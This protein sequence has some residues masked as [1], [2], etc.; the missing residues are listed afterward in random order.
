MAVPVRAEL[1]ADVMQDGARLARAMRRMTDEA[2]L[3]LEGL[4]RGLPRP[5]Q[6][7]AERIQTLDGCVERLLHARIGYFQRRQELVARLFA[8][9][10]TPRQQMETH[11]LAVLHAGERLAA[12]MRGLLREKGQGLAL[13]R[14]EG[15]LLSDMLTRLRD[16]FEALARLL[17]S[18]SYEQVLARGFALVRDGAGNPLVRAAAVEPGSALTIEFADGRV[19]ATAEG[20]PPERAGSAGAGGGLPE[21]ARPVDAKPR[22]PSPRVPSP[23]CQAPGCQA[24][25]RAERT[26]KSLVAVATDVSERDH[27]MTKELNVLPRDAN[28]A[29]LLGRVWL[30]GVGP[31]VIA[32]RQGKALDISDRFPLSALLLNEAEPAKAL[33]AAAAKGRDLG[34]IAAI[35][36]NSEEARR[37]EAEPFLLAPVDL[38]AIK[39]CG[40]T[41]AASLLERVIEERTKG[42]PRAADA[43]RNK[44][45]AE[46]GV[47]LT[48][49]KPGSEAAR[50]AKE[51]LTA[52]GLWSQYL[53]VG[54][55]PDAEVFTKSQ[56]MSALGHGAKVGIHPASQWSNPEPEVVLVVDARGRLV[57][58]TLGNDVNLRDFE[59]RSALLL[60]RGK[61]N[62]GSCAIGPFIRLI[63]GSF[64]LE[65]IRKADLAL[66][67]AGADGFR[68]E[69]V[70]SMSRISRDPLD[71][72][73]QTMGNTHQYPD[74]MV[75]FTGTM[76]APT[77]DRDR[78]GE[79]FT[80]KPGDRVAI[81]SDKLGTLANTVHHADR[82]PPWDFGI[83]ALMRNLASRQL[84]PH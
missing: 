33:A 44:L 25:R 35:I 13:V 5:A 24:E 27:G 69:A 1:L 8:A 29:A 82:I 52:R 14:L 72:I 80:H 59:G 10:P 32:V 40:V 22:V 47:D 9:L 56:P 49:I 53:E 67:I 17:G 39:A 73:A 42:D 2:R 71:L 38:Q 54:I 60:G 15:R 19:G 36:D 84:L 70:S 45:M 57:G 75:L 11:R 41:F 12:G 66:E 26:R 78:P 61:D 43:I 50:K 31:A 3:R 74:G 64:G 68:L 83:I 46:L 58:A 62:N 77:K 63:D 48:A 81:S 4:G 20:G 28:R 76:F 55:G 51:M 79:G 16:R 7:I 18:L 21:R 34:P 6:L 30:P 65:D 37:D 23:G